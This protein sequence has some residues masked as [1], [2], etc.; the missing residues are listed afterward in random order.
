[1]LITKGWLGQ[2]LGIAIIF[3]HYVLSEREADLEWARAL[4]RCATVSAPRTTKLAFPALSL[5]THKAEVPY[6]S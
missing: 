3:R 5:Y 2:V 1:M 6:P 4:T